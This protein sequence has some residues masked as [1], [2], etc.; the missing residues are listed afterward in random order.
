MRD[1]AAQQNERL[2]RVKFFE[3]SSAYESIWSACIGR[4]VYRP[5]RTA[6]ESSGAYHS[7]LLDCY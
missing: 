6:R 4:A 2:A 3:L 7:L 5:V 1:G